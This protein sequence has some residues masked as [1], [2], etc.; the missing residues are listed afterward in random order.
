MEPDCT[1]VLSS[2]IRTGADDVDE[3]LT[4]VIGRTVNEGAELAI[5]RPLESKRMR[6]FS[7][8]SAEQMYTNQG[9]L[10]YGP[11]TR[12]YTENVRKINSSDEI[13]SMS[14]SIIVRGKFTSEITSADKCK[15]RLA[16]WSSN[17]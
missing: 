13:K 14:M 5:L 15:G 11:E 12:L 6:R 16:S 4:D 2:S 1:S 7:S 8:R 3:T 9:L 10:N 17:E